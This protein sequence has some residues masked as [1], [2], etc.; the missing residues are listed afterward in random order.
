MNVSGQGYTP[1]GAAVKRPS[2]CHSCQATVVWV[3]L[4]GKRQPLDYVAD[5]GGDVALEPELFPRADGS[6][7]LVRARYISGVTTRY[8]RHIESCPDAAKWRE[9]W[10]RAAG[11][12]YSKI[13]RK[14][15][16]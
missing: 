12:P 15:T 14:K 3:L 9:R 10:K 8:R 6:R 4:D 11:R 1:T 13:D 16:R 5:G 2:K 7:D